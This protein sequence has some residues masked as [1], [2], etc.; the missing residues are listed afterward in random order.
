MFPNLP[1]A[2]IDKYGIQCVAGNCNRQHNF[3]LV[4]SFDIILNAVIGVTCRAAS[5]DY[6]VIRI[7]N[8][9]DFP[10]E[11]CKR[12]LNIFKHPKSG[13][14]AIVKRYFG[15]LNV[16]KAFHYSGLFLPALLN[17]VCET[18]MFRSKYL[19]TTISVSRWSMP[20]CLKAL[21]RFP[22]SQATDSPF[23]SMYCCMT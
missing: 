6:I 12:N 1:Q 17:V 15:L 4:T 13:V 2:W 7:E 5:L 11:N 19:P 18:E 22:L 23:S 21:R 20:Y 10:L 8:N 16:F 14:A 9:I 3:L